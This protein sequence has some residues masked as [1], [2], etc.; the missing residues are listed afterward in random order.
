[1]SPGCLARVQAVGLVNT[2]NIIPNHLQEQPS[3]ITPCVGTRHPVIRAV[4]ARQLGW[5]VLG[6]GKGSTQLPRPYRSGWFGRRLIRGAENTC[7]VNHY[8]RYHV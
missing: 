3:L 2:R 5:D 4:R 1:M 6:I 7:N 8:Q